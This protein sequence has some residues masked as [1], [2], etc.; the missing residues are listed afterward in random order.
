MR[1]Y[2]ADQFRE[3]ERAATAARLRVVAR[4]EDKGIS[5][6]TATRPG[7]QTMLTAARS[8]ESDVIVCED[9][10]RLWRIVASLVPGLLSWGDLGI[11]CITCTGE[12]TRRDGWELVI[13]IMQAMAEHARREASYPTRRGQEGK[14]LAEQSTGDRAYGHISA[15]DNPT[16][17]IQIDA[18]QAAVVRRIFEPYADGVSPRNIAARFNV[19]G[20]PSPGASWKV[21]EA[22]FSIHDEAQQSTYHHRIGR[23]L[24]RFDSSSALSRRSLYQSTKYGATSRVRSV[25]FTNSSMTSTTRS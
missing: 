21:D 16:R 19:E 14:A 5:G 20:V 22:R 13:E 12:G 17:Q 9:I 25:N 7:Y 18:T 23:R 6:G 8:H 1:R 3:C 15:A 24:T 4:F 10:S 11:H 2:I